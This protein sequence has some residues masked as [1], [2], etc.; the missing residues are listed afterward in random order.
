MEKIEKFSCD[1]WITVFEELGQ[2]KAG[3]KLY[4]VSRAMFKPVVLR[5][6]NRHWG[7]G[8]NFWKK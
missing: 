5:D 2:Q 1:I 8:R 6:G 7:E 4:H 3:R